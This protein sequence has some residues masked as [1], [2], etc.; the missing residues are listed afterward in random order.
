ME[1]SITPGNQQNLNNSHKLDLELL[2]VKLQKIGANYLQNW[3][4]YM[5]GQYK[6]QTEIRLLN[7]WLGLIVSS[8]KR[9]KIN[10]WIMNI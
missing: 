5:E 9:S 1:T 10:E 8:C 2:F 6:H 3:K 7:D 4:E